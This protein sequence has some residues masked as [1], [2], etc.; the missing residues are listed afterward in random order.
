MLKK[1]ANTYSKNYSGAL[2]RANKG[3]G[4]IIRKGSVKASSRSMIPPKQNGGG[5]GCGK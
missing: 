2:K 4:R 3:T 5:C 1:A